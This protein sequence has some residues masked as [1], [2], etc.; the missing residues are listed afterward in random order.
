MLRTSPE[1]ASRQEFYV[2]CEHPREQAR[3]SYQAGNHGMVTNLAVNSRI[4]GCWIW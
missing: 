1:G 2:M 3:V 4:G